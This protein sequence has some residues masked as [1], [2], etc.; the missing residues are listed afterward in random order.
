MRITCPNCSA[1]YEIDATLIPDEGRDVQCSNC[2]NTWFET[3]KAAP[4]PLATDLDWDATEPDLDDEITEETAPE[5]TVE[6]DEPTA[7]APAEAAWQ[8][9]TPSPSDDVS[10]GL[11]ARRRV[12]PSALEILREE[13]DRE[14][15]VRRGEPAPIETQA[16]AALDE[17][18]EDESPSRA[19]R[20]R[21]SR[22]EDAEEIEKRAAELDEKAAYSRTKSDLLPDIED[23]NSSLAPGADVAA[24]G[25]FRAGFATTIGIALVLLILY[26]F[27]PSI[28]SAVPA[29]E[30]FFV[31]YLD[32]A[33]ALRDAIGG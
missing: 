30:G 20:A 27:G 31:A 8:E 6:P 25:S 28:A 29:T 17:A 12:D 24:P 16:E 14:L 5:D 7:E 3:K 10:D 9:S 22:I 18:A 2:G 33:N 23:I 13:A 1:Q 4:A 11:P 19:W 32:A 26:V 15:A 21:V